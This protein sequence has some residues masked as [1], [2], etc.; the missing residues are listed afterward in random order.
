MKKFFKEDWIPKFA[1]KVIFVIAPAITM[2]F[3]LLNFAVIP[4]APGIMVLNLNIGVLF[5]LA[6]SSLGAYSIVLAGWASNNN[7]SLLGSMR[8]AA[9]MISYEVFMGLSLMG[10]VMLTGSF[11]LSDIVNAQKGMWFVFPQ[12]IGFIIFFIAGIAETHRLSFDLP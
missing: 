5:F 3:V 1:D 8:G 10:V 4:F 9:Q 7:Y 12:I 11:N 6:C 2:V